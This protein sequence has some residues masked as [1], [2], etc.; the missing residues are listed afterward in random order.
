MS[1]EL[2]GAREDAIEEQVW[3]RLSP[4]SMVFFLGR[5]LRLLLDNALYMIA[6]AGAALYN[7]GLTGL[8]FVSLGL[9]VLFMGLLVS[10]FIR[11]RRFRFRFGSDR[12]EVRQG[13]I[14]R[15]HTDLHYRRV[16][17]LSVE[18][19][20]YFRPLGL[21]TLKVDTA[22]SS[23]AEVHLAAIVTE[24]AEWI[25]RELFKARAETAPESDQSEPAAVASETATAADEGSLLH[26]ARWQDLVLFGLASSTMLWVFVIAGPLLGSGLTYEL[27]DRLDEQI[28]GPWRLLL[29]MPII[30]FLLVFGLIVA[31]MQILFAGS[32]TLAVLRYHGYRLFRQSGQFR[33]AAG[34][35]TQREQTLKLEKIQ[36]L[37]LERPLPNLLRERTTI[38]CQQPGGQINPM[39]AGAQGA[40]A[41]LVPSVPA[42]A[43]EQLYQ[44]FMP[45]AP[46]LP[47][48]E[49]FSAVH[50][51][52]WRIGFL[53]LA[54]STAAMV[55]IWWMWLGPLFALVV[56]ALLLP[57]ALLAARRR[58]RLWGYCRKDDCLFVR[59]GFIG[60]KITAL[61]LMR[62]Q[63]VRLRQSP[64][65]RW[66]QI[67]DIELSMASGVLR[68]P[69]VPMHDAVEIADRAL[70]H[71]AVT[72]SGWI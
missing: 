45:T 3:H 52:V 4:W 47:T 39:A 60:H 51:R 37:V 58:W 65:Q 50:P 29:D 42:A 43:L 18:R 15:S 2:A 68:V 13:L 72:R 44:Q 69:S 22:G 23:E 25:R 35:F 5:G 28:S 46:A 62:V 55:P 61:E 1:T 10:A 36:N 7:Q 64:F 21:V 49:Q 30:K 71:A 66:W 32:V 41:F 24:R 56:T 59:Q 9:V 70:Y 67:A 17:N 16:Q 26:R 48:A 57:L 6:P 31:L 20:W 14:K 63:S 40:P 38:R 54:A 34:L 12:L 8:F 11:Y 33:S 27:V 53:G 19:P